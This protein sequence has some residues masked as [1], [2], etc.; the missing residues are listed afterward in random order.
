MA[1]FTPE[2]ARELAKRSHEP[3]SKR[4]LIPPADANLPHD[5]KAELRI[6]EEQIAR[7]RDELNDTTPD[8]IVCERPALQPH[9][10]AQLMKSLLGFLDKRQD[11]LGRPKVSPVKPAQRTK[12]ATIPMSPLGVATQDV[13]PEP[14]KPSYDPAASDAPNG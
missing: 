6:V 10:R 12:Q 14:A 9:H 13:P 1:L 8:C 4:H 11:L 3:T 2:T 5:V 7:A